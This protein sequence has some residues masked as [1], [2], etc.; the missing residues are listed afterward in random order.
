MAALNLTGADGELQAIEPLPFTE[1]PVHK[2]NGNPYR[3]DGVNL[4]PSAL[5]VGTLSMGSSPKSLPTTPKEMALRKRVTSVAD[6]W[7][8]HRCEKRGRHI[9]QGENARAF[10]GNLRGCGGV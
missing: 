10:G 5:L 1:R 4:L 3:L 7:H 6:K 8:C 9:R 2:W